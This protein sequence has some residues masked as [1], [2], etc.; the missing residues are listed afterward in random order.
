MVDKL[1]IEISISLEIG[2]AEGEILGSSNCW[3]LGEGKTA[4]QLLR[5]VLARHQ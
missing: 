5:F 2:D 4:Y 3:K 1:K